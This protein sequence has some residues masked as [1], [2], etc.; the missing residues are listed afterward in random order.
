V[1]LSPS[2]S[3]ILRFQPRFF[4]LEIFSCFMGVPSGFEVSH[5]TSPLKPTTSAI[6]EAIKRDA[7]KKISLF[8]LHLPALME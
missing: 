7:G 6:R 2:I 8:V 3:D 1:S 4:N 5:L